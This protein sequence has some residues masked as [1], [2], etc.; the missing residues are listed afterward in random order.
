[1]SG[2]TLVW[3]G[4]DRLTSAQDVAPQPQF[5]LC[6]YNKTT[7]RSAYPPPTVTMRSTSSPRVVAYLLC[8]LIHKLLDTAADSVWQGGENGRHFASSPASLT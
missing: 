6:F 7:P 8:A 3:S 2:Q 5:L 4:E 1:M